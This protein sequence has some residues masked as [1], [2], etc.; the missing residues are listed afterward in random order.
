MDDRT[1][2]FAPEWGLDE[3]AALAVRL[4]ALLPDR[5]L[6]IARPFEGRATLA[7]HCTALCQVAGLRARESTIIG[8]SLIGALY[9]WLGRAAA[10]AGPIAEA[11]MALALRT[12]RHVL[13][14]PLVTTNSIMCLVVHVLVAAWHQWQE[15][16]HAAA[17]E[18]GEVQH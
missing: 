1:R 17:P 5:Q 6:G 9:G 15:D 11:Q 13:G 10:D 3:L 4:A 2:P 14:R 8:E 7:D 16:T 18:S 12:Q